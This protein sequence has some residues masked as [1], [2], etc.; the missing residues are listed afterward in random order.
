ML[1][2]TFSNKKTLTVFLN[3]YRL[4]IVILNSMHFCML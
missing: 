1:S 2:V 3:L 4:D